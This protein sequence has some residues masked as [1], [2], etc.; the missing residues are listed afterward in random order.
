[1]S[2]TLFA[3]C[4]NLGAVDSQGWSAFWAEESTIDLNKT[5]TAS[6]L[7]TAND[8]VLEIT[9]Q[10]ANVADECEARDWTIEINPT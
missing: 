8:Q 5:A 3:V 4:H 2:W 9:G 1:L 6:A 10:L 7:N